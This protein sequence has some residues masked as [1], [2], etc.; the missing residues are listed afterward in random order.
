[1]EE[2]GSRKD[3]CHW[4][5]V[6]RST[7]TTLPSS[8]WR[9]Y[10]RFFVSRRLPDRQSPPG[11]EFT[12]LEISHRASK[13]YGCE[14]R[15]TYVP[16]QYSVFNT[17]DLYILPSK[18]S[19]RSPSDLRRKSY[20]LPGKCELGRNLSMM[21]QTCGKGSQ[22]VII[23]IHEYDKGY[24][25][26]PSDI[27]KCRFLHGKNEKLI[28]DE[29][30]QGCTSFSCFGPIVSTWHAD[31][32]PRFA[33]SWEQLHH[34]APSSQLIS[35]KI[36]AIEAW[37]LVKILLRRT[38]WGN[39][40]ELHQGSAFRGTNDIHQDPILSTQCC[41]SQAVRDDPFLYS[42]VGSN[43]VT[44]STTSTHVSCAVL[45]LILPPIHLGYRRYKDRANIVLRLFIQ[46]Y[47]VMAGFWLQGPHKSQP[48]IWSFPLPTHT[49]SRLDHHGVY[50]GHSS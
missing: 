43:S 40:K 37:A 2:T 14:R 29:T 25:R 30:V 3:A 38:G 50:K 31:T 48:Y 46:H 4:M 7:I 45:L 6:Q 13:S 8:N 11:L 28:A 19:A 33:G 5:T 10:G 18:K 35:E 22:H 9:F 34:L 32:S 39:Y 44:N 41:I 17:S 21:K 49:V 27:V 42:R 1:M 15:S 24:M 26:K 16:C 36:S 20:F 23:M 47:I 12:C